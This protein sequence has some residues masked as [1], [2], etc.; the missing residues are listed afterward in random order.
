[1]DNLFGTVCAAIN[2]VETTGYVW[3]ELPVE[4]I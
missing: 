4:S 2:S 3:V 1:M